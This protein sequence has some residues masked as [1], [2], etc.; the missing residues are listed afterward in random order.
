MGWR[1]LA[2]T[3]R[4]STHLPDE[5]EV[6][7]GKLSVFPESSSFPP[8]IQEPLVFAEQPSVKLCCQLCC[9]VFKDPVITTCGVRVLARLGLWRQGERAVGPQR[10]GLV[11][12]P[13]P[14]MTSVVIYLEILV[15]NTQESLVL[16]P[17]C[18]RVDVSS[19]PPGHRLTRGALATAEGRGSSQ[20]RLHW[21]SFL[22]QN[23]FL[24]SPCSLH[25]THSVGDVP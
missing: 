21:K 10:G 5:L 18:M 7:G 22:L 14:W 9:S 16:C 23:V 3:A 2:F 11:T 17:A 6:G 20:R 4:I 13:G 25:S 24:P 12:V 8:P 1:G 15:G 19:Q